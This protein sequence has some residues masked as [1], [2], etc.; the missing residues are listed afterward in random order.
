MTDTSSSLCRYAD[1]TEYDSDL[2]PTRLELSLKEDINTLNHWFCINFLP[3]NSN[4]TQ[5][6]IMGKL[7]YNYDL[8]INDFPISIDSNLKILGVTVDK[9][10]T[11]ELHIKEILNK[12]YAKVEA[13]QRIA[14]LQP[15]PKDSKDN[16][17]APRTREVNEILS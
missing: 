1:R 2:C 3:V 4:K 9:R 8:R 16:N 11:N 15:I 13:L 17:T 12:V 6:M 10:L 7:D 5:A 14:G